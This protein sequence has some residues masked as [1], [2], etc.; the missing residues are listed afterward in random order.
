MGKLLRRRT[1]AAAPPPDEYGAV[2][3]EQRPLLTELSNRDL[4]I[5][6]GRLKGDVGR[7]QRLSD[8]FD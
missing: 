8:Q 3:R 4:G 5:E 2:L 6:L 1:R 7:L